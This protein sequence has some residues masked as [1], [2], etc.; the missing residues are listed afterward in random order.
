MLPQIETEIEELKKE[1]SN[2]VV[3]Q[4]SDGSIYIELQDLPLPDGWNQKRASVSIILP[5]GYPQAPPSGFCTDLNIR[6]SGERMPAGA[7]PIDICGKK[8][9]RFCWQTKNPW[10]ASKEGLWKYIKLVLDR[11]T[12][13]Q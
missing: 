7:G 2:V 12:L 8:L 6:L 3:N 5:V 10:N 1:Y 11:F 9:M 4:Q 13:L